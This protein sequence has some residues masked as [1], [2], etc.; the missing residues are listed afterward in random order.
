M[1]SLLKYAIG[2]LLH[3][4]TRSW[5]TVLS[6]LM[7]I[8]AVFALMSFGLGIQA[9]VEEVGESTGADKLFL[10]G[11]GIGAPG[12]DTSFSIPKE[13]V[14]FLGKIRGVKDIAGLY[15]QAAAIKFNDQIK[16]NW[17]MGN[18]PRDWRFLEQSFGGG[19]ETGRE[20]K[21]GDI[22][23]VVLGYNYQIEDKVFGRAVAL[24]DK[25]E[26]NDREFE[27]VGFYSE[28][29][30]P[31]DDANIY[32]TDEAMELMYPSIKNKYGFV[33]IQ[34]DRDV[35]PT[36][37]AE[38][39]EEEYRGQEEGKED[40]YVQTF[41]DLLET[42]GSIITVLNSVL[43]LIALISLIVA[44]VNIMNT[45]Y[46]SVLE[47]TKEIGVMKAI[48]ARNTSIM[49]IFIYESGIL[50]L[51]GGIL[52]VVLGFLVASAAG[53]AAA[54]AGYSSLRPIFPVF[55]VLGCLLFSF[56][57]GAASGFFP[58]LKASKLKPANALRYE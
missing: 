33:I 24:G 50:G 37:L 13:D 25:V 54:A 43:L 11:K 3:R 30:N 17:A 7:G 12:T 47:R 51:I 29:G 34:A 15:F 55:L 28:I 52:G 9:Y 26:I 46:T 56:L 44:S 36:A 14:D 40:F 4:K 6:I 39:V 35:D 27:V 57:I 41:T 32:L 5:L 23:K 42:F 53:G 16:Y 49:K 31:S 19:I 1:S 58:A 8:M 2:N 22:S 45:M 18:E 10:Q 20:L 48:G 38:R 21:Q